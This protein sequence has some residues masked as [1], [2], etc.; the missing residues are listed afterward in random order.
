MFVRRQCNYHLRGNNFLERGRVKSV[1]YGTESI[2]FLAPKI[3][4][5]LPND[6][7]YPDTLEIFKTKIKKVGS[8]RIPHVDYVKSIY[9]YIKSFI[10]CSKKSAQWIN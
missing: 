2:S 3:W 6:I 9:I 1:R 8:S 10:L 4:E 7:K 5:T